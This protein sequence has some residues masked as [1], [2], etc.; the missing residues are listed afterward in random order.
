MPADYSN[1]IKGGSS[2]KL[3]NWQLLFSVRIIWSKMLFLAVAL[4]LCFYGVFQRALQ[5]LQVSTR[6]CLQDTGGLC[7]M[8]LPCCSYVSLSVWWDC[9]LTLQFCFVFLFFSFDLCL[10][11]TVALNSSEFNCCCY[12]WE[13]TSMPKPPLLSSLLSWQSWSPS[14]SASSLWGPLW[15]LCRLA[16]F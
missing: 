6:F 14:S 2:K 5:L 7:F 15:W 13:L 3:N 10:L 9:S 8:L 11:G 16:M 1:A 12:R 4:E